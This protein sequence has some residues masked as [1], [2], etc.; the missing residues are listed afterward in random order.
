MLILEYIHRTL[1]DDREP[2][3]YHKCIDG[4][5]QLCKDEDEYQQKTIGHFSII[6]ID[7]ESAVN[8]GDSMFDLLDCDGRT[9]DFFGIYGDDLEFAPEVTKALK[10][11][12]RWSPNM[13]I[14]DHLRI[15]PKYRGNG[16]G[17]ETLRWLQFHFSTG[18]GLVAMIPFPMQLASW[19]LE[20][21][22]DKRTFTK[23]KLGTFSNNRAVAFQR[24]R[25][26][27]ARAGFV[28]V[29]GT[30]FMVSDPKMRLPSLRSL[31][32]VR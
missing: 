21:A 15:L 12:E 2:N 6:I 16:Y 31:R 28:R 13:L 8:E 27:F 30:D 26:Y 9:A 19:D 17:L 5:V 1:V 11:G 7:A 10:G 29:P 18:C 23:L 14:I 22:E 24:L 32:A 20:D 4:K 25:A 3:R